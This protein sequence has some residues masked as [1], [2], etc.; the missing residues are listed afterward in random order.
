VPWFCW[1]CPQS[2]LRW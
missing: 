1:L 2:A